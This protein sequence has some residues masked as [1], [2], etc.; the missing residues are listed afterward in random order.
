[1]KQN[2]TGQYKQ[3]GDAKRAGPQKETKQMPKEFKDQFL[4]KIQFC[5]NQYD[6][7]DEN[8]HLREK[9][10]RLNYLTELSE[11]LSEPSHF[12]SLIIPN[13]DQVFEMIE[14]NIFRP[15]PVLKKS[16][17]PAEI[18]QEIDDVLVDPSWPHLQP[19]YEFFLQLIVNEQADVKSLKVFITHSFIQEFLDLFDAE[20]PRER[21]YLKNILH[22]LYAK[23][24]PRRKMIR[25]AIN[26]CFHTLIH[27]NYKFNGASELLDILASIISG[28]AVPLRDEHVIFFQTVIIP[29]HK[30][31]SCHLYHEQLLRCSMLFLSKDPN[32]AVKLVQGLLRYWPFANSAKEVMFLTEL[33]EVLEVCEIQKLEKLVNK[34]FKRLI[35]CIAGPHLQVADRAMCF[36]ENDYFL[37]ILKHYKHLTFPLLVPVIV[38]IAETHWHKVLQE[39]LNALKTILKEIDYQSFEKALSSKN[40][41]VMYL[42]Q[43][44]KQ[45]KKDRQKME[46][47]WKNLY[48][49]ASQKNSTLAEPRIP[50]SDNHIVGDYNGLQNGNVIII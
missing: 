7:S 25:K 40:C 44:P 48:K 5:Q 32:L 8:K 35:N 38:Q 3:T 37:T 9:Q 45:L 4:K 39:S 18:D 33:L 1:M 36:F 15:L 50:Y 26:D 11:L 42:V 19:V 20:E 2:K 14:K 13:L 12:S 46:D 41:S 30:V 17:N 34:L 28:F 27:E 47:K 29:L 16:N 43:D 49:M 24:V 10:E 6:F 22:R 23:L 21:E 31:Q